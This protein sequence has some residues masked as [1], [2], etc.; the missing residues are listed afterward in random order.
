MAAFSPGKECILSCTLF[1]T[2]RTGS[3]GSYV[4]RA[5]SEPHSSAVNFDVRRPVSKISWQLKPVNNR[6]TF[7]QGNIN[8]WADVIELI[9]NY[10]LDF[11]FRSAVYT[12]QELPDQQLGLALSELACEAFY[13]AYR[14]SY[15]LGFIF[16]RP[17]AINWL[18]ILLWICQPTS[19]KA[20]PA[21]TI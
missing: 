20:I 18:K 5:L 19:R 12:R 14:Y 8:H 21:L 13:W 2:S 11:I 7:V 6:S 1:V 4:L 3:I 9:N 17:I 15:R 16:L 10:H